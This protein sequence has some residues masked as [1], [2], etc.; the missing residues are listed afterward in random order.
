[1]RHALQPVRDERLVDLGAVAPTQRR[2]AHRQPEPPVYPA[3]ME[4][5][6][7][8]D[9]HRQVLRQGVDPTRVGELPDERPDRKV[10]LVP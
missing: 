5:G 10:D 6:L 9:H 7:R 2:L 1:M 3:E 4:A 8:L